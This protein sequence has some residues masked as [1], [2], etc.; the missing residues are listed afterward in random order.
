MRGAGR[1]LVGSGHHRL[2]FRAAAWI[3]VPVVAAEAPR[4]ISVLGASPV[5][6]MVDGETP[7]GVRPL[8]LGSMQVVHDRVV[9]TATW[10]KLATTSVVITG[11]CAINRPI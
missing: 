11:V 8:G 2:A 1:N 3:G 10:R 6:K 4:L 5:D 7:G 9:A